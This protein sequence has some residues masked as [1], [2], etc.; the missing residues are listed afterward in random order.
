VALEAL[1]RA[2][3]LKTAAAV[4]ALARLTTHADPAMR[5]GAVNALGEIGTAG[6]LQN[7]D[8]GIDDEDREVRIATVRALG[9]RN[10]RAAVQKIE[11]A[12]KGKRLQDGD[13]TEKM[14]FFEAFGSLCGDP[15][16]SM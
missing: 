11:A 1:R 3:S 6:A 10:H 4:P 8:R 14:A 12:L 5:L 16:V 9:Q 7:L 15:G 13:L 2:G